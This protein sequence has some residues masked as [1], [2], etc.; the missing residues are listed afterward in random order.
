MLDALLSVLNSDLSYN[1]SVC[2]VSKEL[3]QRAICKGYQIDPVFRNTNG[4][5]LQMKSMEF[6]LTDGKSGLHKTT[7]LFKEAVALYKT[8]KDTY[9][10]KLKEAKQVAVEKSIKDEFFKW[11][12]N[13]LQA[14]QLS[15]SY[16]MCDE[17]EQYCLNKGILTAGLFEVT[18]VKTVNKV[19]RI[20]ASDKEFREENRRSLSKIRGVIYYYIRFLQEHPV[21]E[22]ETII[23][24]TSAQINQTIVD[25]KNIGIEDTSYAEDLRVEV[26]EQPRKVEIE[27]TSKSTTDINE[28]NKKYFDNTSK[29]ETANEI[30]ERRKHFSSWLNSKNE[31]TGIILVSLMDLSKIGKMAL[32]KGIIDKDIYLIDSPSA[33][34]TVSVRLQRCDEFLGLLP[35]LQR[36]YIKTLDSYIVYNTINNSKS[37]DDNETGIQPTDS[38]EWT[39]TEQECSALVNDNEIDSENVEN[40]EVVDA[41]SN[42]SDEE[43]KLTLILK[44]DY[45]NGFRIK[46]AIDKGRFKV[47]YKERFDK[48]LLLSDEQLIQT[49]MKMGMLRE[50]R[51]YAK[52]G[53]E[54]KELLKQIYDEVISV[55]DTGATCVYEDSIYDRYGI[56]L[57][58]KLQM[59]NAGELGDLLLEM[60][61]GK[62]RRKHTFLCLKH[63]Q[64]DLKQDVLNVLKKSPTSLNY[65][66]IQGIM[67]YVPIAKVKQ[68]MVNIKSIVY[69]APETYFFAPNLP[70]SQEELMVI[71]Q[72]INKALETKSHMTDVELRVAIEENC[73]SVAINTEDFTTYGLRNSLAYILRDAFA[74]NGPIISMFGNELGMAEVFVAYCRDRE[75]VTTEELKTLAAD[76]DT[77]IYWDAV[78]D[79]TVRISDEIL[80]RDDQVNFDI[81]AIDNV[82]DKLSA[83]DYIPLKD[84]GLFMH[85]PTL[86]IPW[87]GYV[88]ESYLYK[89]SKMFKLLHAGFSA[90]GYF[91][92]MV[93]QE[94]A[95]D[96][97]RMMIVDA[98]THSNQ[99]SN[100]SS[101]L[102][103]FVRE[104]YQQRRS[105][106]D[107]ENVILEA[108]LFKEKI[109]ETKK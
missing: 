61:R 89:Y 95:I 100:K 6:I 37:N 73:P 105:Y 84:I 66:D 28:S 81:V 19:S 23:G 41:D 48:E 55:F 106:V 102:D 7:K 35:R 98:L 3:R 22:I 57:A 12:S 14:T 56:E 92:A 20:I 42:F 43:G 17:I 90:S 97:Y 1:E 38:M 70:V 27:S 77:V 91:G 11:I 82:L 78:R 44:E 16:T 62:L 75:Q 52:Q 30:P 108:K 72:L 13:K 32:Q 40:I 64:S 50:E 53:D 29:V 60:S 88:L 51:I 94:C 46:S 74:F 45:E 9:E 54:Q 99:W 5:T 18:N 65:D 2:N 87:N 104:G 83:R 4:I 8:D 59:Y 86:S 76:M 36:Q 39:L 33:L 107:I 96:N 26:Y 49:L 21:H 31:D 109:K 80:L 85:F 71:K 34:R 67:W 58:D 68:V 25:K 24:E 79:V 47:F 101:A 10:K 93:R 15:D 69:V 103:F 63:G